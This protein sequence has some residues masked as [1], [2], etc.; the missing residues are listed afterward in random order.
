MYKTCC[1]CNVDKDIVN[2][3]KDKRSKDGFRGDC[4]SCL[5]INRRKYQA[6]RK[7]SLILLY[8]DKEFLNEDKTCII[9]NLTFMR[10]EFYKSGTHKDGHSPYCK[11]CSRELEKKNRSENI[12]EWRD[13]HSKNQKLWRSNNKNKVTKSKKIYKRNRRKKDPLFRLKESLCSRLRLAVKGHNKSDNTMNLIG[14]DIDFLKEYI[15]SQFSEGMC[16]DNYGEW[17]IDHIIPCCSFDFSSQ[18]EQKKCFN[19]KNLRPLWAID[20]TLKAI[21]DKKLSINL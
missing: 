17:H 9:C 21:E 11:V 7:H 15:E 5:K 12:D 14:C 1:V 20:N 6:K 8:Q 10:K 4:I 2:F 18:D 3:Y 13:K 19:Y 16:W